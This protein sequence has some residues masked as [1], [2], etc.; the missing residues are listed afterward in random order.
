M[1]EEELINAIEEGISFEEIP[2]LTNIRRMRE[3]LENTDMDGDTKEKLVGKL[4]KIRS[5]TIRHSAV[6]NDM[7]EEVNRDE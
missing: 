3:I 2:T 7:L 1:G 5:D 4:D 6:F